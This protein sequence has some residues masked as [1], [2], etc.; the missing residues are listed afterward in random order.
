MNRIWAFIQE[1]KLLTALAL[2]VLVIATAREW[3]WLW[4]LLFVFW[5]IQ[6]FRTGSAFLIEDIS[7]EDYPV[8][9]WLISAMWAA[10]GLWYLYAD[11]IWR[12]QG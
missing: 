2:V 8:L 10:F 4:G 7:R 5:S 12:I 1:H 6:G 11:L 9:Y 3:Y